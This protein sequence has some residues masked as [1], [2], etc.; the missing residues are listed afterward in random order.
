VPNV[1]TTENDLGGSA[2]AT[3]TVVDEARAD[4]DHSVRLDAS[5][6]GAIKQRRRT[7][8][9]SPIVYTRCSRTRHAVIIQSA[10]FLHGRR[11]STSGRAPFQPGRQ[12]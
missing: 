12:L 4:F 9:V 10:I 11:R 1:G 7:L 6:V 8:V 3:R 5:R 2:V